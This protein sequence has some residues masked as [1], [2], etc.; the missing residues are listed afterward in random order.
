MI[1]IVLYLQMK[2]PSSVGQKKTKA[3]EQVLDELGIGR[4]Y[5]QSALLHLTLALG[6]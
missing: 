1:S 3:I 5:V 4:P 2:L 6:I